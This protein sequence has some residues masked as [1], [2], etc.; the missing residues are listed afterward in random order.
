MSICR[1]SWSKKN[2]P[3]EHEKPEPLLPTEKKTRGHSRQAKKVF[4]LEE[5]A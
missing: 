5:M 2:K 4:K 1:D 3:V